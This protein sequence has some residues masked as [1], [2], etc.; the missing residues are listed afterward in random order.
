[1]AGIELTTGEW[2]GILSHI[3]KWVANLGRASKERKL[4][5]KEALRSVITAVRE[6]EVY[7]RN[8]REGGRKSIKMERK[9]SVLWTNLAFKLEDL[10]LDKLAKRCQIKG[11]YWADSSKFTE[12]FLKQAGTRLTDIEKMALTEL[13]KVKK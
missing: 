1:M 2:L 3:K 5:S 12:E 4:Q 8:L 10:D 9:L 11:R 7:M 13:N 6:T